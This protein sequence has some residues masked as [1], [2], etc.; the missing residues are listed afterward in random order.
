MKEW[1][2][3][4]LLIVLLSLAPIAR[5]QVGVKV[6]VSTG[7]K[8]AVVAIPPPFVNGG[9]PEQTA[10]IEKTVVDV[11]QYDLTV[12]ERFR[13]V[14]N[15]VLMRKARD[16]DQTI[17]R[18]NYLQWNEMGTDILVRTTITVRSDGITARFEMHETGTG[19]M[20]K[21]LELGPTK[22]ENL[23]RVVHKFSDVIIENYLGPNSSLAST[24]IAFAR[25]TGNA[26]EIY[27]IDYDGAEETLQSITKDN[28]IALCPA[29]S[30]D[31]RIISYAT[32]RQGDADTYTFNRYT[33]QTKALS[34]FGGLDYCARWRADGQAIVL[35]LSRDWNTEIYTVKSDG[36]G[37]KRMTDRPDSIETAPCF[38]PDGKSIIF[39]T[40]LGGRNRLA[41][42]PAEGGAIRTLFSGPF[43][44][45][46][47]DVSPDGTRVVFSARGARD[48]YIFMVNID[49]T[50]AVRLFDGLF[51]ENPTWSPDGKWIIFSG[52]RGGPAQLY[53]FRV[54]MPGDF[55]PTDASG[56]PIPDKP[57][58]VTYLSGENLSPAWSPFL[59]E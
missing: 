16:A 28:N 46:M 26:K 47:P 36:T 39:S 3:C 57:I 5:A 42:M 51:A 43:W 53:R 7:N 12:A 14:E 29:W 30:P 4:L 58:Q 44:C 1:I 52:K 25:K 19:S 11:F 23:R 37:F 27:T 45:E 55:T 38:T 56:N 22:M 49:G 59:K 18:I 21:G 33:G 41:I 6:D 24:K 2:K 32:Y 10:K 54:R 13:F 35:A 34:T 31:G 50:G 8:Q 17:G 15:Q 48:S 40:D 9:N 20:V